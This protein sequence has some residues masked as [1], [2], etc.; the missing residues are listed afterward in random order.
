[1]LRLA[2]ASTLL[3]GLALGSTGCVIETD[4]DSSLTIYNDSSYVLTEV[5]LAEETDPSWGPNLLPQPLFPGD[6]LIIVDIDCGNY[7]ALVVDNTGVECELGNIDLCFD[8]DTWV[9]DDFTLDVCAF[10]P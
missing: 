6:E 7:D 4:G 3:A 1:M 10:A 8:D 2:L 5:Y 9:V